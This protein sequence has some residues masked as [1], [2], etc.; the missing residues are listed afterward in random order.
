[1]AMDKGELCIICSQGPTETDG[2]LITPQTHESWQTLL[3][4]AEIRDYAPITDAAKQVEENEIPKVHY[5]RKCQSVFTMKRD[6]HTLMKRKAETTPDND[7]A[8]GCSSKRYSRRPSESRVYDPVCIFCGKAKYIKGSKTR[9]KLTQAVQLRADRTLREF[10][11][12]KGD[13][14]ILAVTSRDIVAAEA[15][16]HHSCYKNY[17]RVKTKECNNGGDTTDE[18]SAYQCAESEAF[19]DIFEYVRTDVIPNKN[20]VPITSLTARLESSILSSGIERI[21]DSTKKHI[22]RRLEAELVDSVQIFP[23]DKGKLL[24]VPDSVT[25]QM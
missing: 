18:D 22:R 5:H 8:S 7:S 1:M 15:H 9:E 14:N 16:Y 17:T 20:I 23:D 4:A 12:Q 21:R 11:T 10:A 2:H 3:K 25:L 13:K 6:L 24:M 19:S